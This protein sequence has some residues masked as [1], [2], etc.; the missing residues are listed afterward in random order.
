MPGSGK[1]R[2][3]RPQLR[4]DDLRDAS[5]Y[6]WNRLESSQL[7]LIGKQAFG[8]LGTDLLDR[9]I[10]AV[11]MR[12]LLGYQEALVGAEVPHQGL[13]EFSHL[14]AHSPARQIR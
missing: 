1:A 5:A 7:G 4:A 2:Q 9:R 10:Q 8:N 12:Q 6:P 14:L 11:A 3:V 13:L